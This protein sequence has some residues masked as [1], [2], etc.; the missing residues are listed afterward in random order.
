MTNQTGHFE[1][2]RWVT[3]PIHTVP[4]PPTNHELGEIVKAHTMLVQQIQAEVNNLHD[5]IKNEPTH[6]TSLI[7]TIKSKLGL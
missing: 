5:I 1:N 4:Y 2:G 6:H 7:D 3:E